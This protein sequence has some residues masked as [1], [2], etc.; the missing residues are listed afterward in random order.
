MSYGELS[1]QTGIII[2]SDI[3][4]SKV[5]FLVSGRKKNIIGMVKKFGTHMVPLVGDLNRIPGAAIWD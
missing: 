2:F 4:E 3:I 1:R 5:F